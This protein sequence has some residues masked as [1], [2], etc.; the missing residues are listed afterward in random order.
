MQNNSYQNTI[1]IRVGGKEHRDWETYSIESDFL[2][3]ADAFDL[4]VGLHYSATE[5]PD[6]SGES[7]EVPG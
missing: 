3:P 1:A 4:T 5:I 2:I 6:L 7:C